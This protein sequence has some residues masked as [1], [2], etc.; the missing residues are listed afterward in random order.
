MSRELLA[1]G[2]ASSLHWSWWFPFFQ[3]KSIDLW[4]GIGSADQYSSL[5]T[6]QVCNPSIQF[7]IYETSL[8][9]LKSKRKDAVKNVAA[10]EVS[11][12]LC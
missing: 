10:F 9:H 7:M 4:I 8:K 1:S 11:V 3:K 6:C 12:L 2:K 5:I